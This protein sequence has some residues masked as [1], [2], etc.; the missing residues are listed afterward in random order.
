MI[1]VYRERAAT[2]RQ[3]L[4]RHAPQLHIAPS[5]GGSALWVSGPEGLDTQALARDAYRSGVVIE[6]G[7]VFHAQTRGPCA[8]MR[9]GY[10]SIP[11]H[12]IDA[13][14]AMLAQHLQ[15]QSQARPRPNR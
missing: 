7:A 12:A 4:A 10:S 2:L 1:Q 14:V 8:S 15:T 5:A 11:K 9:V 3:A 6:P 13:G